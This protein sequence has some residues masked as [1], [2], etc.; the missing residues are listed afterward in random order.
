MEKPQCLQNQYPTSPKTPNNSNE[1]KLL[2]IK[3]KRKML[4]LL[5][6]F[7]RAEVTESG[8]LSIFG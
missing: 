7:T 3:M 6:Y 8:A 5:A 2:I 1:F 4:A